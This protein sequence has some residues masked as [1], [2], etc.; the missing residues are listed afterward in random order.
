ME[1]GEWAGVRESLP[2]LL[3][4]HAPGPGWW[5]AM[6]PIR[7]GWRP[8]CFG[9]KGLQ[10]STNSVGPPLPAP[11]GS[12]GSRRGQALTGASGPDGA[13]FGQ[14]WGGAP[15][16]TVSPPR[17]PGLDTAL[18]TELLVALSNEENGGAVW[19]SPWVFRVR[20]HG[21]VGQGSGSRPVHL[22]PQGAA[23]PETRFVD[24]ALVPSELPSQSEFSGSR[25]FTGLCHSRF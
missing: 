19:G 7:E 15:A 9:E 16:V 23:S 11:K 21:S 17:F 25:T 14:G 20:T 6:S 8:A 5:S 18:S 13:P 10:V 1:G 24:T 3:V 4:S 12:G 22:D 2:S